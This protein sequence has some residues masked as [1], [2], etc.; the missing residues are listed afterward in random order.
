[1][2]LKIGE[3]AYLLWIINTYVGHSGDVVTK[4]K[5]YNRAMMKLRILIGSKV[6]H[7]V[8]YYSAKMEKI[9]EEM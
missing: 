3:L 4:V 2:E 8:V 6:I 5:L 1:M 7:I 9:L